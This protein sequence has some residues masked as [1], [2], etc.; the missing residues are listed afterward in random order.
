MSFFNFFQSYSRSTAIRRFKIATEYIAVEQKRTLVLKEFNKWKISRAAQQY[1]IDRKNAQDQ[2]DQTNGNNGDS[3]TEAT[4][5]AVTSS[6]NNSAMSTNRSSSSFDSIETITV[7]EA[8]DLIKESYINT[9]QQQSQR[10]STIF[11]KFKLDTFNSITNSNLLSYESDLQQLLPSARMPLTVLSLNTQVK[12]SKEY[13]CWSNDY[14][15]RA[16]QWSFDQNQ[17][18]KKDFG[19]YN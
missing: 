4:S 1:W 14:C 6:V 18:C 7:N 10:S 2:N 8:K 12:S 11:F 16:Q 3:S 17:Y 19:F 9:T 5:V 13:S 15:P